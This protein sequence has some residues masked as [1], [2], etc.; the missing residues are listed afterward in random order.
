M[1][2]GGWNRGTKRPSSL[3][4]SKRA[5]EQL[6]NRD[7]VPYRTALQLCRELTI[8]RREAHVV[9]SVSKVLEYPDDVISEKKQPRRDS[10]KYPWAQ[11]RLNATFVYGGTLVNAKDACRTANRRLRPKVFRAEFGWG[12]MDTD[13]VVVRRVG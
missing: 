9:V 7:L 8:E 3:V 12:P 11:M 10:Q 2:A 6:Q 1:P 13:Q 4:I 5:L